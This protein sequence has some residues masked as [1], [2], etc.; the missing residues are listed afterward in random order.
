MLN[1]FTFNQ[2]ITYIVCLPVLFTVSDPSHLFEPSLNT[3]TRSPGIIRYLVAGGNF[4]CR[5]LLILDSATI[6][7]VSVREHFNDSDLSLWC[8]FTSDGVG[9][10]GRTLNTNNDGTSPL[11]PIISFIDLIVILNTI[12]SFK[13]C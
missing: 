9:N 2:S 13:Y 1:G 6:V 7:S 3:S 4:D 8:L 11:G 5:A 10:P 12:L